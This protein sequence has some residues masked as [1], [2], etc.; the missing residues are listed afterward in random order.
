MYSIYFRWIE[1]YSLENV[2]IVVLVNKRKRYI[3][4]KKKLLIAL[5]LCASISIN[6]QQKPLHKLQQEFEDEIKDNG[7]YIIEMENCD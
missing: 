4:M 5:C 2:L 3:I 7:Y 1:E 6:A